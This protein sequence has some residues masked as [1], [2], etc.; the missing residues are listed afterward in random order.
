MPTAYQTYKGKGGTEY[1][2]DDSGRFVE[3]PAPGAT[4]PATAPTG[5]NISPTPTAGKGPLGA[6]PGQVGL[7]DVA[8]QLEAQLPG[9]SAIN[10]QVSQNMMSDLR[11]EL[12]PNTVRAIQDASA[13]WGVNAGVPGSGLQTQRGLRDVGQLS[14]D[15]QQQGLQNYNQTAQQVSNTQTISPEAQIGASLQNA[16]NAASPDPTQAASYAQSLFN[17]YQ[18][19]ANPMKTVRVDYMENGIMRSR[20]VQIPA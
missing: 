14:E 19:M 17:Q 4:A 11:G 10:K 9:V 15:L 8:A 18:Q 3:G 5:Y 13:Q 2:Y 7:P 20:D 12:D 6:V 1:H 16:I